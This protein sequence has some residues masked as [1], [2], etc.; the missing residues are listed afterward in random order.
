MIKNI[1]ETDVVGVL[2][3]PSCGCLCQCSTNSLEYRQGYWD[4]TL[5]GAKDSTVAK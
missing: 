4:G 5:D 1:F 3:E 2:A